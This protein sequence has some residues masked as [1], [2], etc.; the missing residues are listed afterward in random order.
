MINIINIKINH[1]KNVSMNNNKEEC[2]TRL[3]NFKNKHIILN[4]TNNSNK[5]NNKSSNLNSHS[6]SS[7][8]AK[9]KLKKF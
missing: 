5:N 3:N 4:K 9:I 7:I 1:K 6:V 2:K 8:R